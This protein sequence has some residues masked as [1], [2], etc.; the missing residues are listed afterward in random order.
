MLRASDTAV[1]KTMSWDPP[2]GVKDEEMHLWDK[3]QDIFVT[4]KAT[5]LL[6]RSTIPPEYLETARRIRKLHTNRLAYRRS[7][8]KLGLPAPPKPVRVEDDGDK[9]ITDPR[10]EMLWTNDQITVDEA[11]H[12]FGPLEIPSQWATDVVINVVCDTLKNL[13]NARGLPSPTQFHK[14][15]RLFVEG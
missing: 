12:L 8:F 2:K 9:A 1:S 10:A 14:Y 7:R 3:Y 5:W 13:P 4:D 6:C 15:L 11:I